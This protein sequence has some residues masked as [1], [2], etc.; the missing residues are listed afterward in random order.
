MALGILTQELGPVQRPVGY[1]SKRL[2]PV[3]TG[4]TSCLRVVAALALLVEEASKFMLGQ[5]LTV[6]TSHQITSVLEGKGHFWLMDSR[7]LKY[8]ALLLENPDI[9]VMVCSSLNPA[10]LLPLSEEGLTVH[11]CEDIISHSLLP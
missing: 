5:P 1:L 8:Q 9:C 6:Y 3:T 10:T 11:Q 2:D 4:W 7:I